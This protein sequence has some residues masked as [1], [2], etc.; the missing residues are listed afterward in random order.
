ML[1]RPS[2]LRGCLCGCR[3]LA[4]FVQVAQEWFG[5]ASWSMC[6]SHPS[7]WSTN[8]WLMGIGCRQQRGHSSG[9]QGHECWT[10][11]PKTGMLNFRACKLTVA[12][13]LAL[14]IYDCEMLL[15]G[16]C[17]TCWT[18]PSRTVTQGGSP[19]RGWAHFRYKLEACVPISC[20]PIAC[21][22]VSA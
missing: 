5:L 16:S 21:S 8:L 11:H 3:L 14:S 6:P 2:M 13:L 20:N 22:N 18:P 4:M 15:A 1:Q 19:G 17:E 12:C 7:L 10:T 9:T